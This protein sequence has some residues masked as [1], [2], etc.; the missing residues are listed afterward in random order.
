[1]GLPIPAKNGEFFFSFHY[2]LNS[3]LET[4]QDLQKCFNLLNHPNSLKN[5]SLTIIIYESDEF[6]LNL[7]TSLIPATNYTLFN[8]KLEGIKWEYFNNFLISHH[9]MVII[10]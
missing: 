3:K 2:S 8:L 5:K 7:V 9:P 1:M 6:G 10:R 4:F